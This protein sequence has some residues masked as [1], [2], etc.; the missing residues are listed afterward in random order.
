[1]STRTTTAPRLALA[2]GATLALAVL[3]LVIPAPSDAAK[4]PDYAWATYEVKVEGKQR[5]D[6]TYNHEGLGGCDRSGAGGGEETIK[7]S[8]PRI[9]VNAYYGLADPVTF[10][11]HKP[12]N[13]NQQ[14]NNEIPLKAKINRQGKIEHWGEVGENCPDGDGTGAAPPDCGTRTDKGTIELDYDYKQKDLLILGNVEGYT[15][16]LYKN[17]PNGGSEWPY[18]LGDRQNGDPIGQ[19]IEPKEMKKAGKYIVLAQG[20]KTYGAGDHQDRTRIEWSVSFKRI[21]KLHS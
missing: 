1:M 17:C 4:T 5:T 8:S 6:W 10:L 18:L 21:G 11:S 2:L 16:N 12:I 15:E 20:T 14:A 19:T 13:G 3:C 7:F 9:K